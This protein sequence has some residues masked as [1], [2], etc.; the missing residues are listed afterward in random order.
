MSRVT[1]KEIKKIYGAIPYNNFKDR[2]RIVGQ[3]KSEIGKVRVEYNNGLIF[4][5]Y[6]EKSS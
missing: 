5:E 6:A 1:R 3:L 4:Y 2:V